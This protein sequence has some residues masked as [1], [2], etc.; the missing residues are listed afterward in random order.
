MVPLRHCKV[1]PGSSL[2]IF[3]R[4]IFSDILCNFLANSDGMRP[5]TQSSP[6][7][8][9]RTRE[10]I[11]RWPC[12]PRCI[13][14]DN[15]SVDGESAHF[16]R[17]GLTTSP[18]GS[19]WAKPECRVQK[20]FSCFFGCPSGRSCVAVQ[21]HKGIFPDHVA[22]AGCQSQIEFFKQLRPVKFCRQ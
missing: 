8:I 16:G 5:L 7:R 15:P 20:T 11:S 3:T 21:H 22:K 18:P 4:R 12:V 17:V 2:P 1:F 9:A 14:R 13:C 10:L 19:R 6:P